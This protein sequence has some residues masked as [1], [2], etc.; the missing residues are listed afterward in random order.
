[1]LAFNL[2]KALL[3]PFQV[4]RSPT[5][6]GV[7]ARIAV[8]YKRGLIGVNQSRVF[9]SGVNGSRFTGM[10]VKETTCG[11]MAAVVVEVAGRA[12]YTGTSKFVVEEEDDLK[13]G[14]LCK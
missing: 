5:G 1:M 3:F 12:F 14:F 8:Q 4:D 2:L 6:S 13:Q 10:A 9:A 7:T 11:S